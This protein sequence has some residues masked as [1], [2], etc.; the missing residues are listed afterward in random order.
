MRG[1]P[2]RGHLAEFVAL[3]SMI[4]F[5]ALWSFVPPVRKA[6]RFAGDGAFGRPVVCLPG[7]AHNGSSFVL[8]ARRLHAAGIGPVS[9]LRYQPALAP[10]ETHAR[11]LSR[12]VERVLDRTGA[13]RVSLIGHSMGGLVARWYLQ[14]MEGLEKV[15]RLVTLETPHQGLA[16]ARHGLGACARQMAPA[17]PFMRRM[18]EGQGR[19][20]GL[21]I[22]GI[23]SNVNPLS[24]RS[25]SYQ[26]LDGRSDCFLPG[27][28]HAS[29]LLARPAAERIVAFLRSGDLREG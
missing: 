11:R 24:A 28:G 23:Y 10:M 25:T 29:L 3:P 5:G 16:L 26:L 8:L 13:R 18:R 14:E 27:H 7:Y 17:H 20:A 6:G 1:I 15:D 21:P 9:C 2:W 22:L 19:M 4:V 12:A